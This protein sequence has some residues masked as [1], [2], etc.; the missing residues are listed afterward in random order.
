MLFFLITLNF[1][2]WEKEPMVIR[3][4]FLFWVWGKYYQLNQ[5]KKK[6]LFWTQAKKKPETLCTCQNVLT[7]G[8]EGGIWRQDTTVGGHPLDF[9]VLAE[10]LGSRTL[11][12]DTVPLGNP[13]MVSVANCFRPLAVH[14]LFSSGKCH[15]AS[16]QK[17]G[18]DSQWISWW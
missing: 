18:G 15:L 13:R 17:I 8:C 14:V 7:K 12:K 5:K 6:I 16:L 9:S 10:L 11:S 1:A 3:C 2:V 4:K